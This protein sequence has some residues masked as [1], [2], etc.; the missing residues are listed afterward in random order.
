LTTYS[1]DKIAEPWCK[2]GWEAEI[3]TERQ[4]EQCPTALLCLWLFLQFINVRMFS[5]WHSTVQR[6][7]YS[8]TKAIH[9]SA[10]CIVFLTSAQTC[11]RVPHSHLQ[12]DQTK[13]RTHSHAKLNGLTFVDI[14]YNIN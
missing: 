4:P 8:C 1:G 13:N 5:E 3:D 10:S 11:R 9:N 6:Q 12:R 7:L 14:I 2:A